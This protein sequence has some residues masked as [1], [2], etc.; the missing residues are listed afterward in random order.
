MEIAE[1]KLANAN[2]TNNFNT[3]NNTTNNNNNT[4]IINGF[5]N[6][7]NDDMLKCISMVNENVPSLLEKVHCNQPEN[8]NQINILNQENG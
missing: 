6:F 8:N 5:K 3:T 4:I 1:L 7:T 2:V